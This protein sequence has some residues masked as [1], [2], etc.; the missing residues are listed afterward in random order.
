MHAGVLHKQF[1]SFPFHCDI[2]KGKAQFNLSEKL[3]QLNKL[4]L[5]TLLIYAAQ[6][7]GKLELT[8]HA[9]GN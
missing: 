7:H 1:S 6:S 4:K 8:Q 2:L 3:G 5:L 9:V